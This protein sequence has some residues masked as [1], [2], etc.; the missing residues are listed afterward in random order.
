MWSTRSGET[1]SSQ[2][3]NMKQMASLRKWKWALSPRPS[4]YPPPST[5]LYEV[6]WWKHLYTKTKLP[7]QLKIRYKPTK[8]YLGVSHRYLRQAGTCPPRP[9]FPLMQG[10]HSYHVS[11]ASKFPETCLGLILRHKPRNRHR[12]VLWPNQRTPHTR[13]EHAKLQ[14][15]QGFHP[16]LPTATPCYL[17]PWLGRHS[18]TISMFTT[19]SCSSCDLQTTLDPIA[20]QVPQTKPTCLSIT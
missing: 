18:C 8:G 9:C 15:R 17:I 13:H 6:T 10:S 20:H 5:C 7:L 1:S 19:S 14:A 4:S 2:L 16:W 3:S 11:P 12:L